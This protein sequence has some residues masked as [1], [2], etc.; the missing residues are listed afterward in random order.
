MKKKYVPCNAM[1]CGKEG[2]KVRWVYKMESVHPIENQLTA[3]PSGGQNIDIS[4]L[5][6]S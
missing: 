5:N 2:K 4:I 3:D 6:T 1:P